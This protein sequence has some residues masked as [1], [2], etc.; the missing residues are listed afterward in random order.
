MK[1][2]RNQTDHDISVGFEGYDYGIPKKTDVLCEE[3]PAEFLIE[4]YPFLIMED[5][6]KV[7]G[8]TPIP[9]IEKKKSKVYM[10]SKPA[11]DMQVVPT[12][13]RDET[14]KSED[15]PNGTDRDGVEWVGPGIETDD[16]TGG[17]SFQ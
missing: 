3:R 10:E 14:M 8:P 1:V 15:L 12:H 13:H 7:K 11:V 9:K 17:K 6:P 5:A 4:R 2:I 16:L